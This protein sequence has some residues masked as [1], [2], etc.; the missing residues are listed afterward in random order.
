MRRWD[1]RELGL[2][3]EQ[4]A[5]PAG[6]GETH[7]HTASRDADERKGAH[8]FHNARQTSDMEM[9]RAFLTIVHHGLKRVMM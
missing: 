2:R 1:R 6:H 3:Q 8:S 4:L 7:Q 5:I 9:P